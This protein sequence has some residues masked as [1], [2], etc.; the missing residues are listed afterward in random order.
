MANKLYIFDL[1][2]TLIRNTDVDYKSFAIILDRHRNKIPTKKVVFQMRKSG[3]TA[4]RILDT[5]FHQ[6]D[7]PLQELIA[8]R[9]SLLKDEDI[10]LWAKQNKGG[11]LTLK[12]L[13]RLGYK[14]IIATKKPNPL[15]TQILK[16]L[17]MI[18]YVDGVYSA[19]NKLPLLTK[20]YR[21]NHPDFD[22]VFVGNDFDELKHMRELGASSF[23]IPPPYSNICPTGD[24]AITIKELVEVLP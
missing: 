16:Q 8:E 7:V 9:K 22:I 4:D 2:D 1:D 12:Y 14:I 10:W 24:I 13:K 23:Y 6:M 20:L 11:R 21:D 19:E 5:L 18:E 15:A 17:G 3:M